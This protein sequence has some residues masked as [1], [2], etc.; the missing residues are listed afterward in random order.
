MEKQQV[1]QVRLTDK[2]MPTPRKDSRKTVLQEPK[3]AIHALHSNLSRP[4]SPIRLKEIGGNVPHKKNGKAMNAPRAKDEIT[5]I[6]T[7][8]IT[9]TNHRIRMS[10]MKQKKHLNMRLNPLQKLRHN[11]QFI[12][13]TV[14]P[15]LMGILRQDT[16]YH[17]YQSIPTPDG[18]HKQDT[19]SYQLP[20]QIEGEGYRLEVGIRNT[21]QYPFRD[22][23]LSIRQNWKDSLV[24]QTDT[25]HFYLADEQGKWNSGGNTGSLFQHTYF[26]EKTFTI[27]PSSINVLQMTHL[28][29]QNPLPGISDAGI[30]LVKP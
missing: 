14:F 11:L 10:K 28:M 23:W 21:N 26:C 16:L 7:G 27:R 29:K 2:R 12:L 24:F 4:I 5:G 13:P 17:T 22:I 25:L 6:T 8:A 19:L 30:R 9:E 20:E 1:L 18:W 15:L 3:T